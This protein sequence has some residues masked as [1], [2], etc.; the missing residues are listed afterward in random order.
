MWADIPQVSVASPFPG[1]EF[2]DWCKENGDLL[3]EGLEGGVLIALGQV[4]GVGRGWMR[5]SE[6]LVLGVY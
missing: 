4:M 5:Y 6:R 3:T 2:Y 1:T